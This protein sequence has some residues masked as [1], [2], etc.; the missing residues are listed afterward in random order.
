[1]DSFV[2]GPGLGRDDP[3]LM[4]VVELVVTTA[5]RLRRP[6]TIDADGLWFVN[7]RPELISGYRLCVITPNVVEFDRLCDALHVQPRTAAALARRLDGVI[8][9]L[10]GE[11]DVIADGGAGELLVTK[12]KPFR[13]TSL[14]S[15]RSRP[16]LWRSGR[17]AQRRTRSIGLQC[18]EGQRL[19]PTDGGASRVHARARMRQSSIPTTRPRAVGREDASARAAGR[20]TN[21]RSLL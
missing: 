7:R 17:S 5:R 18:D 10:K 1:M 11:V 21:V 2:L 3:V 19:R 13:R 9:V 4:D 14:H 15:A 6:L 8:V 12:P 16:S 20:R